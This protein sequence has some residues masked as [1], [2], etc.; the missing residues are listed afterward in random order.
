MEN[1]EFVRCDLILN[2]PFSI[3]KYGDSI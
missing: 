1:G 2:S 3:K